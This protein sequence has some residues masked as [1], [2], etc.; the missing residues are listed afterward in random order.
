MTM[1]PTEFAHGFTLIELV[2]V[3]VLISILAMVSMQPLLQGLNA[4]SRVAN[5]LN[6]IDGLRYSVERIVRELRQTRFDAVGSGLQIKAL[7]APGSSGNSSNGICLQRSGGIDGSTLAALSLR[8]SGNTATLDTGVTYPACS[9]AQA[10]TLSSNVTDLRFDYWT[11]GSGA[12]PV[13]LAVNDANFGRLLNFIDITLTITPA[14]SGSL[15]L[16]QHTR[17]V[18]RNGAWGA[19]K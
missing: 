16:T 17:V 6:V 13:A 14:G 1:R 3:M 11:D 9:A 5:H 4:R 2:I 8:K 15:P 10:Q 7:D 19:A 12:T 18:L